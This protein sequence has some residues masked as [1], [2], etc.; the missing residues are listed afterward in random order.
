MQE[1]D[2]QHLLPIQADEVL[3]QHILAGTLPP[4]LLMLG[5]QPCQINVAI[6]QHHING[7]LCLNDLHTL[8]I[9]SKHR[10]ASLNT[11]LNPKTM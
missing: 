1:A 3:I 11:L 9:Q 7:A 5:Q 2:L 8:H 10:K 6:L 4:V